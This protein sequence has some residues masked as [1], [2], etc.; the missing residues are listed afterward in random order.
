MTLL[1]TDLLTSY[2][3]VSVLQN[4]YNL[5][6]EDI[7]AIPSDRKGFLSAILTNSSK[8]DLL[9]VLYFDSSNSEV[10]QNKEILLKLQSHLPLLANQLV[11]NPSM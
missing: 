10:F 6:A 3:P 1:S 4:R 11:S 7:R 8:S 5:S 9:G 2:E